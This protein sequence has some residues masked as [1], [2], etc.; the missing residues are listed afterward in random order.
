MS[1][2]LDHNVPRKCA[3]LLQ[4]WGYESSVLDEHI[5]ADAGDAEVIKLAQ[6]L[7]AVL[8]T[9]DLDFASILDYPPADYA[10]IVVMRYEA[11]DE[12]GITATLKQALIDLYRDD[13]RGAL[14]IVEPQRYRIRRA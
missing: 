13:L 6:E 10:G 11:A 5:A 1:V 9:A 3:R 12:A 2:L 7:D 4:E 14:V 8:Q